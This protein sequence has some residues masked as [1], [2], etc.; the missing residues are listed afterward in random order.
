MNKR[1][2]KRM[3]PVNTGKFHAR[4]ATALLTIGFLLIVFT[5]SAISA[6]VVSNV[7]ATQRPGTFIVDISYDMV[8]PEGWAAYV[9]LYFSPDGG[10]TWPIRC[11]TITGDANNFVESGTGHTAEWNAE[12]DY[13][14]LVSDSCT[15][16]VMAVDHAFWPLISSVWKTDLDGQ[17]PIPLADPD[18]IA[19]GEPFRLN[20]QGEAPGVVDMDPQM[21]ASL[22]TLYPFD[23]GLL[24]YKYDL[25]F[26]NCIPEMQDCWSPRIFDHA[27]YDSISYFGSI[28]SLDFHNDGS[29]T[30]PFH[31]LLPSGEFPFKLNALDVAG[32]EI[33]EY[34]RW[35]E[36]VINFDPETIIL[37]GE[38]DWAHPEDP[39]VYPYFFR[40][41]DPLKIH[42]PFQAGDR[43][44]DRSYVVV[45]AL[46]RDDSRDLKLDPNFPIA[47]PG[48]LK[49]VRHNIFG[50]Q[51]SFQ[52]ESSILS[53][54]P[55]WGATCDTCW[56]ADTLGFLTA[57]RTTFTINMQAVDEHGRRDG[58]PAELSFEVGYPPCLQCIEILPKSIDPSE[59]DEN[60]ECLADTSAN[61]IEAH[62]C[63]GDTTILRITLEG[64]GNDDIEFISPAYLL[65]HKITGDTQVEFQP[66]QGNDHFYEFSANLY[67]MKLLLH[68][69]DDSRE[70]WDSMVRRMMGWAYQV[71]YECDPFNRTH[72]GGG[73]DNILLPTWGQT[74]GGSGLEIDPDSGLWAIFV[75]IPVPRDLVIFGPEF[76]RDVILDLIYDIQD[77]ELRDRVFND[78]TRQFGVGRVQ[79][80][81]MDQTRCDFF[82]IR[83]ARYNVFRNVRPSVPTL[84][85]GRT[86]R[87][88]DLSVDVPDIIQELDLYPSSMES[89]DG[90]PVSQYFRIVVETD[91]GDF[92]CQTPGGF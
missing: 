42:H 60:L 4:L 12:A 72:D 88:C 85:P 67:R 61:T 84:P 23:D 43:I 79:A 1:D 27:T 17:N 91:T 53:S 39:E 63:F 66:G 56:S 90:V 81:A 25:L 34:L 48:Y 32:L 37:N 22:D 55:T 64:L 82:P 30:G 11:E 50:G 70:R 28:T 18:T 49:G 65:V 92:E 57:P 19:Y 35:N 80:I 21:L 13:P 59:F 76:F 41:N 16:R 87:D 26:D 73:N 40:L 75:D 47:I 51:Y 2:S 7:Q 44:P 86:W 36:L 69:L 15:I 24:G 45:K 74:P 54:P 29:G 20:W 38:T 46:G 71:D 10:L 52:T 9:S 6:P 77:P 62:P 8:Q 33:Q 68:G 78:T 58:A 14:D 3:G 83:P 5:S 89:L 31:E